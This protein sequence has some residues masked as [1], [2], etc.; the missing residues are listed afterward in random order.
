VG[1]IWEKG[2]REGIEEAARVREAMREGSVAGV[3]LERM[4]EEDEETNLEEEGR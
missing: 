3:G 1:V 2:S 4:S